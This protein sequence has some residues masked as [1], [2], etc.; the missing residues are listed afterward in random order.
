MVLVH[1]AWQVRHSY[2]AALESSLPIATADAQTYATF[3]MT[4][5][6]NKQQRAMLSAQQRA[7]FMGQE[8]D[9]AFQSRVLNSNKIS[10][11]ANMQFTAD[12]QIALENS[13]S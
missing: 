1:L 4:N 10:E 5:L 12:Q 11:V 9:Q 3:E 8:F 2:R 13:Q 6:N 7:T